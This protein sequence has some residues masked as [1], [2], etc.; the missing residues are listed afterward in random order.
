M[1]RKVLWGFSSIV[2]ATSLVVVVLAFFAL[3]GGTSVHSA[4]AASAEQVAAAQA[5]VVVTQTQAMSVTAPADSRMSAQAWALVGQTAQVTYSA[6]F[7]TSNDYDRRTDFE[8]NSGSDWWNASIVNAQVSSGTWFWPF[9]GVTKGYIIWDHPAGGWAEIVLTVTYAHTG[10][11]RTM[12]FNAGPYFNYADTVWLMEP[13]PATGLTVSVDRSLKV[14]SGQAATISAQLVDA[15][16][17]PAAY[18][19]VVLTGTIQ[20]GFGTLGVFTPTDLLGRSATTWTVGSLVGD[21]LVTITN[22][23]FT[24][25][26]VVQVEPW[27]VF[28][29]PVFRDWNPCAW[30][31]LVYYNNQLANGRWV[32][33][34]QGHGTTACPWGSREVTLTP[35]DS[36]LQV[37]QRA[38][39]VGETPVDVQVWVDDPPPCTLYQLKISWNGGEA[40]QTLV[41]YHANILKIEINT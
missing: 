28:L 11:A 36:R 32:V 41:T 7:G 31:Y 18:G 6:Y 21:G 3:S 22:G 29:S 38:V 4:N 23:V 33:T 26:G 12:A 13:P 5:A 15:W 2:S 14:N 39:V 20:P 8:V 16:G 40:T 37:S 30:T 10:T 19:N 34:L 35:L 24:G 9:D 25:T 27:R 17:I 1:N